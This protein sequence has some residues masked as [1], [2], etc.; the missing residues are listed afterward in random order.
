MLTWVG[1][2]GIAEGVHTMTATTGSFLCR[3]AVVLL[4][5]IDRLH[6]RSSD[7]GATRARRRRVAVRRGAEE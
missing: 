5:A 4:G 6:G 3:P 1:N 2:G 7:N